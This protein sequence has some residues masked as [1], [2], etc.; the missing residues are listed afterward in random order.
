MNQHREPAYTLGLTNCEAELL[1]YLLHEIEECLMGSFFAEGIFYSGPE[2]AFEVHYGIFAT[3]YEL[4]A[5]VDELSDRNHFLASQ[6][7]EAS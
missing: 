6:L 4:L 1:Y 2:L 7:P 3:Y 5:K